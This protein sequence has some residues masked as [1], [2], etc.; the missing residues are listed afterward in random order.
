[1]A[2]K[3]VVDKSTIWRRFKMMCHV[4]VISRYKDV[5]INMDTTYWGTISV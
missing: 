2:I 1:M 5:V 3:C 4:R